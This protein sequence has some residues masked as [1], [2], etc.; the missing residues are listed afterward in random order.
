MLQLIDLAAVNT[1][2]IYNKVG[3]NKHNISSTDLLTNAYFTFYT[4]IRGWSEKVAHVSFITRHQI[5][6][7]C[8]DNITWTSYQQLNQNQLP[9]E[10]YSEIN[11]FKGT[12]MIWEYHVVIPKYIIILFV[13]ASIVY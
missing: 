13:F 4:L 8:L 5:F 2:L 6:L 12:L 9:T 3:G 11:M 7:N 10:N 1:F